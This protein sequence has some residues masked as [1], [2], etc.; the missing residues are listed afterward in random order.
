[1]TV[2]NGIVG[3]VIK[4]FSV[5]CPVTN[6]KKVVTV[7]KVPKVQKPKFGDGSNLVKLAQVA[8][9]QTKRALQR[10]MIAPKANIKR[11]VKRAPPM[12]LR[13]ILVA[14]N[15]K[16]APRV[17]TRTETAKTIVNIAA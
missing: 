5:H 12:D 14:D 10:A 16:I 17:G 8:N 4:W 6:V 7:V 11:P 2:P 15:A 13:G 1:V 9:I 3:K